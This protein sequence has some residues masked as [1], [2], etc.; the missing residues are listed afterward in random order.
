MN[1]SFEF[2]IQIKCRTY[3]QT[4]AHCDQNIPR[5]PDVLG[6]AMKE[7]HDL[8]V[9]PVLLHV[10]KHFLEVDAQLFLHHFETQLFGH[11]LIRLL[12]VNRAVINRVGIEHIRFPSWPLAQEAADVRVHHGLA[13]VLQLGLLTGVRQEQARYQRRLLLVLVEVLVGV[14]V[15]RIPFA[16]V[17]RGVHP[18]LHQVAVDLVEGFAPALRYS[19][20]RLVLL[21]AARRLVTLALHRLPALVAARQVHELP[22]KVFY[23]VRAIGRGEHHTI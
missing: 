12:L 19:F 11:I 17:P 20:L 5:N 4:L 13:L 9:P 10:R 21:D 23:A 18:L 15:R 14:N 2:E 22:R 16:G 8:R 3:P 1:N 7:E 6:V